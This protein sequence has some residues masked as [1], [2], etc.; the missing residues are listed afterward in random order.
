MHHLFGYL[1][2]YQPTCLS[3]YL[4]IYLS[5]CLWIYLATYPVIYSYGQLAIWLN[6][7][8]SIYLSIWLTSTSRSIYLG[9]YQSI[10]LPNFCAS[11]M[12]AKIMSIQLAMYQSIYPCTN[13]FGCLSIQLSTYPSVYLF[14]S[15]L[16][17]YLSICLWIC[18]AT[19][20]VIYPYSQPAIWLN[21][22]Q[23][24]YMSIQLT[25]HQSIYLSSYRSIVADL[26]LG[27]A[28]GFQFFQLFQ[29]FETMDDRRSAQFLRSWKNGKAGNHQPFHSCKPES[30]KRLRFPAFPAFSETTGNDRSAQ[31]PGKLEKLETSS[32]FIA[33]NLKAG[34]V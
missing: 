21:S 20:P 4:F 30:W 24:V 22:Y 1:P 16:L 14:I 34:N 33:A 11:S 29:F 28:F 25:I 27:N 31:F 19:N 13:L 7:S 2:I 10:Q 23:S 17:I 32:L 9:T 26:R 8:R 18:L 6:S 5:I 12:D 3:V 15:L